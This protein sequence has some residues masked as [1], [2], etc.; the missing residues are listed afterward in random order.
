M[1][2]I[3][4]LQ[5]NIN[6]IQGKLEGHKGI[7]NDLRS[8]LG[9]EFEDEDAAGLIKINL[10]IVGDE[11]IVFENDVTDNYVESNVAYQDHISVKPF[12]YTVRGTVGDLVYYKNNNKESF[13]EA[14]PEKLTTIASFIP[15]TTKKVN[16]IRNKAIKISNFVNS[17]DN[18]SKRFSKL[19]E[20]SLQ[21]KAV[22]ELILLREE[23]KPIKIRCA[24]FN[25][26][27]VVITRLEVSQDKESIDKTDIL[28]SFK[29]LRV[30]RLGNSIFNINDY[31][32]IDK[33]QRSPQKESGQTN[34]VEREF[35]IDE[36]Y[37]G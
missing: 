19:S 6:L 13:L 29:Q 37:E 15:S 7:V 17:I 35:D 9:I 24:W 36:Y 22:E 25:L 5:D 16:S 18:F 14:V 12:T 2:F 1:S 21:A 3:S 20:G 34:G 31:Q 30:A 26:S 32:G 23:R 27:N 11:T 8:F 4:T 33:Q 28:I 10:D